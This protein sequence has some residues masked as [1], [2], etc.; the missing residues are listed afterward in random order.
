M[1]HVHD[2][3][4][5]QGIGT[6]GSRCALGGYRPSST[7]A[8]ISARNL[9][10]NQLGRAYARGR[11]ASLPT[12]TAAAAQMA[13]AGCAVRDSNGVKAG[14]TFVN[15]FARRIALLGPARGTEECACGQLQKGRQLFWSAN[16][17]AR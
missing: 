16:T 9:S 10:A 14:V 12:Q 4:A 8:C 15:P 17:A 6:G 13:L 7:Q 3:W 2:A 5:C 1:R 11:V